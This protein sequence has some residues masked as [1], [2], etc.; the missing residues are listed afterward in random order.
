M[1]TA[2]RRRRADRI[3]DA[4]LDLPPSERPAFVASECGDDAALRALVDRL[5]ASTSD[6]GEASGIRAAGALSGPLWD[7]VVRDIDEDAPLEAGTFVGRYRI[8]REV[9]RGGMGVVHLAERADGA[10]EQRVALKRIKRGVDSDDVLRRFERERR[11]LARVTHPDIAHLLDGGV[12]GEGRPYLVMEFVDGKPIDAWCDTYRLDLPARL[13]LFLRVAKAVHEAHRNLVVHRDIKPS[14]ILVTEG[15][16][17]KLLDF[18]IAKVLDDDG[19]AAEA[20][21]TGVRPMTP[22]WASPEQLSGGA[23]TVS[24][25]VY[26]LGLL[27]FRLLTG[28]TPYRAG[29]NRSP[30]QIVRAVM[31]D[32]PTRPSAAVA[33]PMLDPAAGLDGGAAAE[34]V[35][36]LR[37]TTPGRLAGD[38][39]GDLDTIILTALRKEPE[40]RY[41]SVAGLVDDVQRHLDGRPVSARPDTLFYRAGKFVRRNKV[42]VGALSIAMASLLGFAGTMAVQNARVTRERDR[43]NTEA[44]TSR[45]VSQFLADLFKYADP[46]V[47]RGGE[48]TARE[49]LDRGASSIDEKMPEPSLVRARLK[50]T[51]GDVYENLGLYHEAEPL[52][53]QAYETTVRFK[54]EDDEESLDARRDWATILWRL[55]KYAEAEPLLADVFA[56]RRRTF[57][58]EHPDT[59]RSANAIASLYHTQARY[60]EA[61]PIYREAFEAARSRLG[62]SDR[63]TLGLANNLANALDNLERDAESLELRRWAY[64]NMR[65]ALGPDHPDTLGTGMNYAADLRDQGNLEESRAL[66]ESI[67]ATQRRV[68]GEVHPATLLTQRELALLL[69][70]LGRPWEAAKI[71]ERAVE[72]A[73][74]TLGPSNPETI[75]AAFALGEVYA[76]IPAR[77]VQAEAM[78][79]RAAFAWDASIG[80][81]NDHSFQA[82]ERVVRLHLKA[83]RRADAVRWLG[84]LVD[85]GWGGPEF[86]VD[87]ELAPLEGDA[88]FERLR[89]IVRRRVETQNAP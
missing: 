14:N 69:L 57:G 46:A 89:E 42:A 55:G 15:G 12:D 81:A 82:L 34:E 31:E 72:I 63:F 51:L 84:V 19:A 49:I 68:L 88:G 41:A 25:D 83:G 38:L 40:R 44:E 11:I 77:A 50:R 10:F 21:H 23:V 43:A 13:R 5:L 65:R 22:A 67:A 61:E 62:D 59:L 16:H 56:R 39:A 75:L 64:D 71:G 35:A 60:A 78:Y 27:L 3:F 73:E 53:R 24:S 36:R 2:E 1:D 8:L 76:A 54:G 86:L 32:E 58:M 47:S 9:G 28:R 6:D 85:R 80:P 4:A 26:Q 79:L 7:H 37:G 48:V 17:P 70:E 74:R 20:T 52:H 45:Q 33:D 66:M 29:A 18:G 30:E 87:R